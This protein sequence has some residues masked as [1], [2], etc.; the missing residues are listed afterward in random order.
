MHTISADDDS[1]PVHHAASIAAA[2]LDSRDPV[3]VPDQ[4]FDGERF[5]QLGSAFDGTI[6]QDLVEHGSPRTS[7]LGRRLY[8]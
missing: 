6:D 8:L 7:R 3:S 1:R 5:P 2:T 4:L